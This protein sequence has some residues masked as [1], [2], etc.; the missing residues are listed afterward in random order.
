MERGL[1]RASSP[2][3]VAGAAVSSFYAHH[4]NRGRA[5]EIF[6]QAL[7]PKFGK[8]PDVIIGCGTTIR[9]PIRPRRSGTTS[10]QTS[11]SRGYRYVD[12]MA[13]LTV[14]DYARRI[15]SSR[16]FDDGEFDFNAAVQQIATRCGST[17]PQS[18]L[19]E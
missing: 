8:G 14:L 12:S 3:G 5:G 17:Q 13:S 1:S 4:N 15:A 11:R 9:S 2:R 10:H 16:M 7:N 18:R 6:A 19:P